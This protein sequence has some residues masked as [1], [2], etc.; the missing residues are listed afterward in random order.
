M[1]GLISDAIGTVGGVFEHVNGTLAAFGS[2][3]VKFD[4]ASIPDL[5]GKV[6]LIT[7]G[8]SLSLTAE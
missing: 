5:T 6:I 8:P 4:T 3:S 1:M 7:G 2:G